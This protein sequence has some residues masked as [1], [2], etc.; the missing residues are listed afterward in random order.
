MTKKYKNSKTL[1][2]FGTDRLKFS[3]SNR[4]TIQKGGVW[5]GTRIEPDCSSGRRPIPVSASGPWRET[6]AWPRAT[7]YA[8]YKRR[9]GQ[10]ITA[11]TRE[12][13]L[14]NTKRL[15][16]WLKHSAQ[17]GTLWLYSDE[18]NFCQDQKHNVQNH[19]LLAY[20]AAD[21][22]RVPQTQFPQTVMVFGCVSSEGDVMPPHIFPQSLRL[23]ADGYI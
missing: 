15:L 11:N 13:R 3:N 18:K 14:A 22:P 2:K 21:V 20:C 19:R 17:P 7:R 1:S 6:L 12:K 10:L 23:N 5:K 8:S 16:S 4:R 9:T